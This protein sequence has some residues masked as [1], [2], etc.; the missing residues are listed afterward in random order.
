MIAVTGGTGHIGNVLVR[1]LVARGDRVRVLVTRGHSAGPIAS[2]PMEAVEGDVR[3]AA[4]VRSFVDGAD[5]VYH[6]AGVIRISPGK[7]G[8][9]HDVN[10]GGV[11]NVLAACANAKVSRL[12]YTSSVHA[13]VELP[14]GVCLDEEGPM[15]E[16]KV[17]GHYA[18]SKAEATLAVRAAAQAGLDTV[19][20]YPSG[21]IGPHDYK[22]SE[23]GQLVL[24][25]A[26]HRLPAYVDGAY[27]FVDVRDV[28]AG[29][30]AAADRGR[31]GEGYLLCGHRLGVK[32]IVD[33][34]CN[35]TGARPP[36]LR[37]PRRA[38]RAVS[39]VTPAYYWITRKK[40]LF[41][42]YSIDVLYSNCEMTCAKARR[43]LGYEPRP[44]LETVEDTVRWFRQTGRL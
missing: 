16:H 24:D 37:A 29:L 3:D 18:R 32:E 12:V 6:I 23:M 22:P 11:N 40:P 42:T 26:H 25:L 2:L 4:S 31:A 36:A 34:V 17:R 13:F 33:T 39:R 38:I 1:E 27:D 21:V 5:L 35:V 14:Q 10:V 41:T 20:T 19:V 15:D 7:G 43:E 28:V 44:F 30:I 8:L 9:L